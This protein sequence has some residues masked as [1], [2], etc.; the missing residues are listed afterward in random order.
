[1]IDA[2]DLDRE[3]NDGGAHSDTDDDCHWKTC[4]AHMVHCRRTSLVAKDNCRNGRGSQQNEAG[5]VGNP[6]PNVDDFPLG[7]ATIRFGW[8][9]NGGLEYFCLYNINVPSDF[10]VSRQYASSRD[11]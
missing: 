6:T 9:W 11:L 4:H 5:I 2:E 3:W 7:W 1:M 8:C 10:L